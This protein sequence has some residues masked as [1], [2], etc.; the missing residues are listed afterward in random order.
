MDQSSLMGVVQG[1]RYLRDQLG[2]FPVL[3]L[4]LLDLRREIGTFDVLRD[5]VAGTVI[6]TAN[7]IDR[8][9]AGM[10]QIGHRPGLDQIRLGVFRLWRSAW[11]AAP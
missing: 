6:G 8:D 9:D 10:V 11:R 5:D 4:V 1:F 2:G 7:I 3:E